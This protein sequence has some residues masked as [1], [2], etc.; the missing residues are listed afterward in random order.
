MLLLYPY[1]KSVPFTNVVVFPLGIGIVTL[2]VGVIADPV[3]LWSPTLPIVAFVL[4]S[5][6]FIVTSTVPLLLL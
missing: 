3:Y 4:I 1:V 5:Y 2:G 6:L